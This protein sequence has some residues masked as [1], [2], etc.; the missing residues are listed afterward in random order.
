MLFLIAKTEQMFYNYFCEFTAYWKSILDSE[1]RTKS[2]KL[3]GRGEI[4][5]KGQ[6]ILSVVVIVNFSA[7]MG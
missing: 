7:G 4:F 1:S 5:Q 3:V 6:V 2:G